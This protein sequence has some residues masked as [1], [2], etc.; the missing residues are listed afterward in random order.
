MQMVVPRR[1]PRLSAHGHRLRPT[2]CAPRRERL[3]LQTRTEAA[4]IPGRLRFVI[5]ME[6]S[7][8]QGRL[9]ITAVGFDTVG[10]SQCTDDGNGA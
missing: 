7:L 2:N 5:D 4:V 1:L 8:Q 9:F 6:Q 3:G 10:D